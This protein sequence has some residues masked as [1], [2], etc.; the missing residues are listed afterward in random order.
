MSVFTNSE[1][2]LAQ[3]VA[4]ELFSRKRPRERTATLAT[5]ADS[6]LVDISS[7][8]DNLLWGYDALSFHSLYGLEYETGQDPRE[9]RNYW[10]HSDGNIEMVLDSAPSASDEDV[11]VR[12]YDLHTID[13][14]PSAYTYL[15]V[16]LASAI[17]AQN[18]FLDYL[19]EWMLVSDK[20]TDANTAIDNAGTRFTQ[21]IA[22]LTS[23]RVPLTNTVD[24]EDIRDAIGDAL[25]AITT[26][27]TYY[28]KAN[29]G[30]PQVEYM[31][32]A[33]MQLRKA[34][35]DLSHSSGL[36]SLSSGELNVINAYISQAKTFMN[37]ISVRN[38]TVALTQKYE[39]WGL[40]LETKLQKE[41][42][43]CAI[44]RGYKRWSTS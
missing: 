40:R 6:Y 10:V 44:R 27:E 21:A 43:S 31:N 5:V 22:D 17:A 30:R 34:A 11:K 32:S 35:T 15:I 37:Y 12:Y 7:L 1:L 3:N 25:T 33:A 38:S 13:T 28:N 36:H 24:I 2:T 14:V 8:V 39:E 23:G 16:R 26:A 4:L 42:S 41:L 20:F 18:K 29:V 19:N 9:Y